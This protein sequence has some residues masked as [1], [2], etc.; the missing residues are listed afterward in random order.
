MPLLRSW[1]SSVGL[2]KR[3]DLRRGRGTRQTAAR[4]RLS[5][6]AAGRLP[7]FRAAALGGVAAFNGG[8]GCFKFSF[9]ASDAADI[10]INA[11]IVALRSAAVFP[12]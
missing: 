9:A 6:A 2:F 1:E 5:G 12:F 3:A 8:A 10:I 7:V 4:R 11:D